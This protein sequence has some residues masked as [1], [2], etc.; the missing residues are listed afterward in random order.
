MIKIK[1]DLAN[2]RSGN[3]FKVKKA[4]FMT[5]EIDLIGEKQPFL[6]NTSFWNDGKI[7][8]LQ[9]KEDTIR[10]QHEKRKC[11][12]VRSHEVRYPSPPV[13]TCAYFG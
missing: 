5:T 10:Q 8:F 2:F 7:K 1:S 11:K 13:R 12:C 4:Y 3:Q 9:I 6:T